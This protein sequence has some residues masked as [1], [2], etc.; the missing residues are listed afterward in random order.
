MIDKINE[1]KTK[2]GS[3]VIPRRAG[4]TKV[5]SEISIKAV[6]SAKRKRVEEVMDLGQGDDRSTDTDRMITDV[7]MVPPILMAGIKS[8][9]YKS[10]RSDRTLT[11]ATLEME[12]LSQCG[13]STMKDFKPSPMNHG[14]GSVVGQLVPVE[15]NRLS[16]DEPAGGYMELLEYRNSATGHLMALEDKSAM[17]GY[18]ETMMQGTTLKQKAYGILA[19]SEMQAETIEQ[20]MSLPWRAVVLRYFEEEMRTTPRIHALIAVP[21]V[22]TELQLRFAWCMIGLNREDYDSEERKRSKEEKVFLMTSMRDLII[23]EGMAVACAKR[24]D[25]LCFIRFM[26]EQISVPALNTCV[27]MLIEGDERV[28]A[29]LLL[30]LL[31]ILQ[32]KPMRVNMKE[33]VELEPMRKIDEIRRFSNKALR[34][35][36]ESMGALSKSNEYCGPIRKK[37]YSYVSGVIRIAYIPFL[38]EDI[39][40]YF[41]DYEQAVVLRFWTSRIATIRSAANPQAKLGLVLEE[42]VA[43]PSVPESDKRVEFGLG[44]SDELLRTSL[45]VVWE[46]MRSSWCPSPHA[47]SI[48]LATQDLQRELN[49]DC[50]L[51]DLN[52]V[53]K[54]MTT[55]SKSNGEDK[56]ELPGWGP[57][58]WVKPSSCLEEVCGL[59]A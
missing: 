59:E 9:G 30:A 13:E 22:R 3:K 38:S 49:A 32:S 16:K 43:A 6:N 57:E 5:D 18:L 31:D 12:I 39:R 8:T 1:M 23:Q 33:P 4:K 41:F 15:Y 24:R 11:G 17:E 40:D 52:I 25:I 46:L 47:D 28:R 2:Q 26:I 35:T 7:A 54:V 14:K 21:Y 44:F 27:K 37:S 55:A 50:N 34:L 56:V 42:K 20:L 51:R 29:L 45:M 10:K 19:S 48:L 58:E 36:K 53:Y